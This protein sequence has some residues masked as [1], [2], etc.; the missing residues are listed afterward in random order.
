M[1]RPDHYY[2][3][4]EDEC[5]Y[6]SDYCARQGYGYSPMN[7]LIFNLKKG[8]DRRGQPDWVHKERAIDNAGTAFAAALP[9]WLIDQATM[10]AMPPS[11]ARDDPRYDDRM[12]RILHR[13]RTIKA[14]D[15]RELLVQ[16][17]SR[18]ISAHDGDRPGP[19][20]L[21]QGYRVDAGALEP[22]PR[23]IGLFDDVLVT[24]S[25]FKAAKAVLQS[26]FPDIR[27]V[28][29]YVARRIFAPADFGFEPIQNPED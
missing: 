13:L 6:F 19:E 10:I 8:V 5:V 17:G 24:G 7:Q 9:D 2:L 28:G 4:P 12:Q 27:V 15:V 21:A 14:C 22:T 23:V 1:T 3:Q 18:E 11:K 16:D 20:A 29:I 25:S 26:R